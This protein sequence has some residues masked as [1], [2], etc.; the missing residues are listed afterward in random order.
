MSRKLVSLRIDF[1]VVDWFTA[2]GANLNG[3]I[4]NVMRCLVR[5]CQRDDNFSA[6][7]R[8]FGKTM[9][10]DFSKI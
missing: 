4:N 3:T 8:N 10:Y 9:Y 6:A 2:N 5:E 7:V 1:A